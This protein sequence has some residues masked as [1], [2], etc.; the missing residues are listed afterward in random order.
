MGSALTYRLTITP[1]LL[2]LPSPCSKKPGEEGE[3]SRTR[4]LMDSNA[5]NCQAYVRFYISIKVLSSQH[6]HSRFRVRVQSTKYHSVPPVLTKPIEVISKP[7]VLRRRAQP[8]R[9]RRNLALEAVESL[10]RRQLE[11]EAVINSAVQQ[12]YEQKPAPFSCTSTASALTSS[13]GQFSD[14]QS[15]N[16]GWAFLRFLQAFMDTS[17][18]TRERNLGSIVAQ[19]LWQPKVVELYSALQEAAFQECSS[20]SNS[21]S[22]L[23]SVEDVEFRP[24]NYC[25]A[26]SP[27]EL[28]E[29]GGSLSCF[30]PSN[31]PASSSSCSII[32]CDEEDT[33]EDI[34]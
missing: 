7:D 13:C 21:E 20:A 3:A 6:E 8:K 18:S 12:L 1:N 27:S 23:Q 19:P 33:L 9:K 24:L 2:S 5:S 32:S 22:S 14:S 28:A 10:E 25:G 16:A 34:S 15:S 29:V 11:F 31:Y 26:P 30:P 4:T 17:E